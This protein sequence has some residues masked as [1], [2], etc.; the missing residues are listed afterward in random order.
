[1]E[2][3]TTLPFFLSFSVRRGELIQSKVDIHR[4]ILSIPFCL[5]WERESFVTHAHHSEWGK[6]KSVYPP[7]K[8][9]N[10]GPSKAEG[11]YWNTAENEVA[12]ACLWR[13]RVLL[14]SDPVPCRPP[15]AIGNHDT[16]EDRIWKMQFPNG[17][18][19]H[20]FYAS[21]KKKFLLLWKRR[22]SIDLR[23]VRVESY[24]QRL[25]PPFILYQSLFFDG[26]HG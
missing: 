14:F 22:K 7:D 10:I 8:C 4:R 11:T 2:D 3:C 19:G 23:E 16:R 6:R 21:K 5:A 25:F 13:W 26:R 24:A 15:V 20:C 12:P 17:N 18:E 1:M 9:N